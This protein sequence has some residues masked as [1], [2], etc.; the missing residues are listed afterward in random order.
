[1]K[2]NKRIILVGPT[3]SGKTYARDKFREKGFKVDVSWTT[4]PMRE[5][6]VH[7]FDYYFTSKEYFETLIECEGFYEWVKYGDYYY[8]TG[9]E[10][11]EKLSQVFIMETDG[12]SKIKP[13]DRPDCLIIYVNTP[14][15]TRLKRMR[16]RGWTD[17]KISER[18]RVDQ[19]KFR[20][21]NDYD[22]EI[23]SEIHI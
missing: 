14:F 17:E 8:G 16:E 2:K 6:E 21:F 4:R 15:D 19:Q 13:E 23:S 20:N 11:W 18:V 10:E 9:M 7:D 3:C 1:M 5:G 12:V 22:L